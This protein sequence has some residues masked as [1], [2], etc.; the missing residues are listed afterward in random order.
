MWLSTLSTF[1]VM[2]KNVAQPDSQAIEQNHIFTDLTQSFCKLKRA[3]IGLKTTINPFMLVFCNSFTHL[4]VKGFSGSDK[5]SG[6]IGLGQRHG[7]ATSAATGPTSYQSK[8]HRSSKSKKRSCPEQRFSCRAEKT[9][10]CGKMATSEENQKI[11]EDYAAMRAKQSEIKDK[12]L[13]M[14]HTGE[15]K[16]KTT[17]AMGMVFRTVAHGWP[18]AIVQFMKSKDDFKYG[19]QKLAQQFDNLDIFTM[20]AGFTWNTDNPELDIQTTLETWQKAKECVFSGKYRLVLL[21][22]INYVIDFKFLAEQEVLEMLNNK[23]AGLHLILTGRNA[24]PAII[25][26]ADLVTE[27]V[28]IKHPYEKGIMAQKGIEW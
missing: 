13:I 22:E 20:G 9:L 12:S 5:C 16:G 18:A 2:V 7:E 8:R 11:R 14:V 17:A 6:F 4:V 27:M 19:E 23:P 21:D 10:S 15:G 28:N 1:A 3:F 24:T 25:E 26:K